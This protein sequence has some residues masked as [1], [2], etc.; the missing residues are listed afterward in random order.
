MKPKDLEPDVQEEEDQDAKAPTPKTE[1]EGPQVAEVPETAVGKNKGVV[2]KKAADP[3]VKEKADALLGEK[4]PHPRV[5]QPASEEGLK[6]EATEDPYAKAPHGD[7][8]D[9]KELIAE[10]LRSLN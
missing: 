3:A 4:E 10:Q 5:D 7:S 1:G 2:L 6:E 9:D 8:D